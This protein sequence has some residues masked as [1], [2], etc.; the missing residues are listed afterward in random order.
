L[1]FQVAGTIF[2]LQLLLALTGIPQRLED[3]LNGEDLKPR[4]PPRYI[5]VLGGSGVPSTSTLMRLYYAAQ[6][7]ASLTGT[8][9]VVALPSDIDPDHSSVG[10]MRDELVLRGIPATAIRMETQGRN[11]HQ[12]AVNIRQLL[13]ADAAHDRVLIVTSEY[14]MRRALLIFRKQG[15]TQLSALNAANVDTEAW[16]GPLAW[17]RYGLWGNLAREAIVT[18]ELLALLTSKLA[19]WI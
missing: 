10:R 15:F 8:T 11:T 12:Q 5:V 7:G 19:G 3:W 14:H 13:G 16:P 17:L 6:F 1:V 2:L 4:D 18:R 9:F